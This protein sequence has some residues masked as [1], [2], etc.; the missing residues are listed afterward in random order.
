MII[1]RLVDSVYNYP[2]KSNRRGASSILA[3]GPTVGGKTRRTGAVWSINYSMPIVSV[4][5][6]RLLGH[7]LLDTF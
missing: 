6:S 4:E 3:K 7:V 2:L 5:N 1:N